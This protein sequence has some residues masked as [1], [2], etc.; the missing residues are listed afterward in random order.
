MPVSGLVL[1]LAENE[2]AAAA[3]MAELMADDRVDVGAPIGRR[4]PVVADTPDAHADKRLH[5]E[6]RDL[7][8][9]ESIDVV[10]VH[11]D[12]HTME[13]SNS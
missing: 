12:A 1:T 5:A 4:L 2:P 9:V 11:F 3:A 8:G 13:E 10:F 6:L 7:D